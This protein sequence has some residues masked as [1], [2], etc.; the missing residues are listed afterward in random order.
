M[1]Y[2][3]DDIGIRPTEIMRRFCGSYAG[4]FGKLYTKNRKSCGNYADCA[5]FVFS[6]E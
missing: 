3:M 4:F 6:R 1:L 5:I 2:D